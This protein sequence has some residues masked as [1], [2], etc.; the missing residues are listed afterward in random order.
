M[1]VPL[2]WEFT[3]AQG[4]GTPRTVWP[5]GPGRSAIASRTGGQAATLSR[6][7]H[8]I[9]ESCTFLYRIERMFDTIVMAKARMYVNAGRNSG[10]LSTIGAAAPVLIFLPM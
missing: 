9:G 10:R 7:G 5:P 6:T 1:T 2:A 8:H 3:A 4:H